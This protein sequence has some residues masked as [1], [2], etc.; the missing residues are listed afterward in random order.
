[1][2]SHVKLFTATDWALQG[3]EKC[4]RNVVTEENWAEML[5]E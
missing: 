1:M 2:Y 4:R 3:K 5:L